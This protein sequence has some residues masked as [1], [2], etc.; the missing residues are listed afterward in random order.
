VPFTTND[1]DSWKETVREYREDPIGIAKRFD[2]IL[3]TLDLNW[4]DTDTMLD[5]LTETEKLLVLKTTKTQ[6]Q[7]QI[8]GGTLVGWTVCQCIPL[9]DPG[10]DP[11]DCNEYQQ[12]QQY[13]QWIK[14][15][16]ENAIPKTI[17]WSMLYVVR[18]GPFET[19][20]EFLD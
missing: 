6:V 16:L 5:A 18:Q 17:N 14:Y 19:P 8:T 4:R 7:A 10:W 13:Q 2:M 15:G 3:K 9:T 20:S 11:N 12:L 1:L